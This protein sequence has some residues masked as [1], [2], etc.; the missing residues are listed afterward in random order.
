MRA[1]KQL[2]TNIDTPCRLIAL[3]EAL[4]CSSASGSRL[5]H[6]HAALVTLPLLVCTTSTHSPQLLLHCALPFGQP[7]SPGRLPAGTATLVT[8]DDGDRLILHD[9]MPNA[10]DELELPGS[11]WQ[12]TTFTHVHLCRRRHS[13]VDKLQAAADKRVAA[14]NL[15]Q[16]MPE[17][18]H[19][20]QPGTKGAQIRWAG[21]RSRSCCSHPPQQPPA[22]VVPLPPRCCLCLAAG[23]WTRAP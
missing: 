19:C 9:M 23:R 22:A 3:L 7:S 11:E 1:S 14:N 10:A 8:Q 5:Q 6:L 16:S 15:H 4:T 17:R 18:D 13:P 21:A 2:A 12:P 20:N